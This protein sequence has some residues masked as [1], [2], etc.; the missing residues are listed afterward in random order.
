MMLP[1]QG[2]KV[3]EIAQNL[4]GPYA[5]EILA[6]L[7]AD[8]VKVE[9][10]G[11]DDARGWGPPFTNGAGTTFQTVNR[12]KRNV[13]LDLK[14]PADCDRLHAMVAE[15]DVL[16]QNLR[17]GSLD[18]LGF[19]AASLRAKHPRLIYCSLWAFGAVGPMR[20]DPGYEPM[21]QA[22]AGLFT[23]NG[24]ED[25][26]PARVGVQVLDLGS[27]MWAAM[28][29]IA[30]LY[31]RT[32]TG[33]GAVVDTSLLETALTW[34]S[35]PFASFAKSGEVPPRHRSGNPKLVVFEALPTADIELIVAAANDRLFAKLARVLGRPDWVADPRFATNAGRVEHKAEIIDSCAAIMATQPAA[36][37]SPLLKQ[38]GVPFAPINDLTAL[39]DDPQVAAL[40]MLQHIPGLDIPTMG[41]PISFDGERPP[42]RTPAP[43]LHPEGGA[44]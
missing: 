14:D 36:H 15:A 20:L 10:P 31:R 8:V 35:V 11:G 12:N 28:G 34:M 18:A 37:W 25:A 41:L 23:L 27:G 42:M 32:I 4:A 21:V 3:V 19:D 30:A 6:T 2:I 5:A 1:L 33:E 43:P 17:P 44:L 9:R 39:L 22:F 29:C 24:C 7:G 40:G 26:P 38:A 16:V 13:T